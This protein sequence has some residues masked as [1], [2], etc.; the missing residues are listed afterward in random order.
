MS[1][2]VT[3]PRVDTV[4]SATK[5][6]PISRPWLLFVGT[7]ML[8]GYGPLL[9]L[10]F[11]QQWEKPHYQYFP[12][13][14][15]AFVWLFWER[16]KSGTPKSLDASRPNWIDATLPAAA[17]ALLLGAIVLYSP[18]C[19]MLSLIVLTAAVCRA[20]L[21]TREVTNLWGIW[22]LLWLIVPLPFNVDQ[23][24]TKTLQLVSS[25]LSSYV[26][27]WFG[28]Y[29]LMEGN[30]LWLHSKQ[31]FVDEACSG[32][33][34][35]LSIVACAVVY[36][37]VKNRT[38]LHM[39]LLA[40]MGIAWAAIMNVARIATIALALERWGIDWSAGT[41]HE[42]LSLVLFLLAFLALLAMD[43]VLLVCLAPLLQGRNDLHA[44]EMHKGKWIAQ[45]W[46]A[47]VVF[48]DPLKSTIEA[49]H[50]PIPAAAPAAEFVLP[51]PW[52]AMS[53]FAPAALVQIV[54]LFYAWNVV[55]PYWA[56]E[57]RAEALTAIDMPATLAGLNK[58]DFAATE[59]N[60]GSQDGAHSRTY[61]YQSE[62]GTSYTVSCDFPFVEFWHELTECYRGSGWELLSRRTSA[63]SGVPAS[64]SWGYVESDFSK[65]SG[66]AAV[67]F[68]S[69]F[70]QFGNP[71]EQERDWN[72]NPLSFWES[73][74]LNLKPHRL[75]QVQVWVTSPN[76]ISD[77]QRQQAR[78]LFLAARELIRSRNTAVAS[79]TLQTANGQSLQNGSPTAETTSA[80]QTTDTPASVK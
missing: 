39:I 70:D 51:L 65:P 45:A 66:D 62:D 57:Q 17:G 55:G 60:N 36:A 3:R 72:T 80:G 50:E 29:H 30:T 58:V 19:A 71:C 47:V 6:E 16:Y 27:D 48:G 74:Q 53:L 10:F 13:V 73:R 79:T 35:M 63:P 68:F 67:L 38:P 22:V 9:W 69:E 42:I 23:R 26:L 18:W 78:N 20:V 32:I 75:F 24:L 34:S 28:V 49:E 52:Y 37:V 4:V 14:I 33:I 77:P 8:L 11:S 12:F 56:V 15:A 5:Q 44:H 46:D 54:I 61:K 76:A 41:S 59:R 1:I 31:L 21:R 25:R 43:Q 64:G 40:A 2:A 7:V